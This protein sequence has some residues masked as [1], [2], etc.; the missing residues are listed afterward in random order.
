SLA[1]S[2]LLA[3]A[4]YGLARRIGFARGEAAVAVL[5]LA[6]VP[7]FR[8]DVVGGLTDIPVAALLAVTAWLL[9]ARPASA[10]RAVGLVGLAAAATLT[11]PSALFGLAGIALAIAVGS[12]S[13]LRG[14]L[15]PVALL[16]AGVIAALVYDAVE[17]HST[18]TSLP[19]FLSAGTGGYYARLADSMRADVLLGGDWL[20][21]DLR[22][23][24]AYGVVYAL[25]RAARL[26][27]RPA[28][29]AAAVTAALATWLLP[30]LAS[31]GPALGAGPFAAGLDAHDAVYLLELLLLP[32]TL[33]A[34]ET[35]ALPSRWAA[36]LLVWAVPGVVAWA[37]VSVYAD[38]LASAAWPPLL[39]LCA[40][41]FALAV[42]GA[43]RRSGWAAPVVVAPLLVAG[44]LGLPGVDGLGTARWEQLR[45]L[46]AGAWNDR[47]QV[48]N[49]AFGSFADELAAVRAH[50]GP[51]DRLI[52]SDGKLRFFY[53]HRLEYTAP[54][55]CADLRGSRV[56][57]LLT[58][59]DSVAE[60]GPAGVQRWLACR[61]PETHLVAEMP[62]TYA[63]FVVGAPPRVA[64]TP[65][66]CRVP[67]PPSGIVAVF[68]SGLSQPA[69]EKLRARAAGFGYK[70]A[71]VE[72]LGCE[73]YDV[74]VRG[75]TRMAQEAGVQA[76]ARSVGLDV[77]FE[78]RP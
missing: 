12:H 48:D 56:F 22:L 29:A 34:T 4:I 13:G 25:L 3:A 42:R 27:A 75:Y 9:W 61:D 50:L 39:L 74:V 40:V 26:P 8:A 62:S 1:F 41:P 10:G 19:S 69:A 15:R 30:S 18:G 57:V 65:D 23:P 5:A 71:A 73:S 76:E 6:L 21:A 31:G 33:A 51:R 35:D 37:A 38:R 55:A 36:R 53:V 20:G 46:G 2:A 77:H 72:R 78:D 47:A 64:P 63:V 66:D 54:A 24:L 68:G 16:A 43:R 7:A 67:A 60:N 32:L 45:D 11:K 52:S 17:A 14:R 58:D 59:A 44:V 28:A 70:D 49:I